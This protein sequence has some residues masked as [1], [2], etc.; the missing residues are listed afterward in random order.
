ML[1]SPAAKRLQVLK[2]GPELVNI[3]T[4]Y[5]KDSDINGI[6]GCFSK[7]FSG[8]GK[9]SAGTSLTLHINREVTTKAQKPRWIPYPLK[10]VKSRQRLTSFLTLTSTRKF[11]GRTSRVRPAVIAPKPNKDDERNMSRHDVCQ[12]SNSN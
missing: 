7:V 4:I 8:V 2:V 9:L 5:F 1:G 6:V 12:R 3:T 11:L 10:E